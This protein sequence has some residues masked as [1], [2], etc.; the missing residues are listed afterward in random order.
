MVVML[1][2]DQKINLIL[3]AKVVIK[4]VHKKVSNDKH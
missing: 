2:T 1:E 3:D 4:A